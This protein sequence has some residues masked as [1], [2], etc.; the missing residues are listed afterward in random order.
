MREIAPTTRTHDS[1]DDI[2]AELEIEREQ[3]CREAVGS[4]R[5]A[6]S[7]SRLSSRRS[8]PAAY[9]WLGQGAQ[10]D[11]AVAAIPP[12]HRTTLRQRPPQVATRQ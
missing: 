4:A 10:I 12:P 3:A 2:D 9:A 11:S 6:G 5:P 8:A 7:F 1:F